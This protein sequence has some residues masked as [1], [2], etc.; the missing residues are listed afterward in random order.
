MGEKEAAMI[1]LTHEQQQALED[2]A[3]PLR[4]INPKTSDVYVLLREDL[5]GKVQA[6]VEE[7]FDPREA[8]PLLDRI[9]AEDDAN[10][11]YLESYQHLRPKSKP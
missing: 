4:L 7:D 8:Y 1:E 9:M 11:P 2:E 10:D 3:Q 6:L 5:Y